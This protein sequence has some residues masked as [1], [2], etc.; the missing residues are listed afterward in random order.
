M[1]EGNYET[2]QLHSRDSSCM[3]FEVVITLSYQCV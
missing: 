3:E 1:L 2:V